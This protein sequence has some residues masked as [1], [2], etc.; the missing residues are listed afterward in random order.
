[1]MTPGAMASAARRRILLCADD[2]GLAAG[3]DA[4]IGTLIARGRLSATSVMVVT[5]AF[6]RGEVAPPALDRPDGTRAAL[7]LH[8]T[9]TAPHRPASTAFHPTVDG[10]F[11]PLG[12]LMRRALLRRLDSSALRREV[13]AQLERFITAFG[14]PPE[15]V[16]GHQHV[17]L[18]PQVGEAVLKAMADLAPKAWVRQ[19]G[20]TVPLAARLADRKG[21]VLDLLSRR[22]R[23][24]AAAGGIAT[25]PAFA[26]TY[27]FATRTR[28]AD[29]FPGFLGGLPDGGLIMCHPGT[30]DDELVSLDPLT[31]RREE[32]FAFLASDAVSACLTRA[33]ARLA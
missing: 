16:D 18:L 19:C 2:F 20:R 14:R 27:E 23:R 21:L 17:Q 9:L 29:L 32:E 28:F 6:R 33:G 7:G 15:F 8:L 12:D 24:L 13:T 11:P 10:S 4:A 1:V 30:V 5:P 3:V 25:N 31:T 26:G 22:F